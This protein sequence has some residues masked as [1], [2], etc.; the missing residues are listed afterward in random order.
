MR[1]PSPS[2]TT[3]GFSFEG[4]RMQDARK[5]F[6]RAA[7][8]RTR[9][10]QVAAVQEMNASSADGGNRRQQVP[11]H[12]FLLKRVGSRLFAR[13]QFDDDFRCADDHRFVRRLHPFPL[14][15][16]KH[17]VA[18]RDVEELVK[19][20][21]ATAD[22]HTTQRAGVA[23]DDEHR[24]RAPLSADAHADGVELRSHLPN[25][26]IALGRMSGQTRNVANRLQDAVDTAMAVRVDANA[27]ARD[28]PLQF[29][30]R[31][32]D[33]DEIRTQ[34]QN[35]LGVRIEQRPDAR[36]RFRVGREVVIAADADDLRSGA[37]G[38]QHLGDVR[39]ERDDTTSGSTARGRPRR[40]LIANCPRTEQV[41]APPRSG[42]AAQKKNDAN[43]ANQLRLTSSHRKKG[44]P[45]IAVTTPT[46]TSTGAS[47]VRATKSH[48]MR[49]AA[50]KSAAA[51]NTIR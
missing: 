27:V 12:A 14:D 46:G 43:E 28:L 13:M 37:D 22:I 33:N 10:Q 4:V 40:G 19:K 48:A 6:R 21:D 38:K 49:N 41:R 45:T 5:R 24:W 44:P 16:A 42:R 20:A 36:Q 23:A 26:A 34:R 9:R 47:T 7:D 3:G 39:D 18:A 51:G 29:A 25:D 50:P 30:L 31:S 1:C 17:I 32:I 15:I 11:G 35:P 2:S 8:A